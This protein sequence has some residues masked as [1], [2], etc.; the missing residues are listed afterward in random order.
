M[1]SIAEKVLEQYAKNKA[2]SGSGGKFSS[3][4]ERMKKYF[5]TILPKGKTEGEKRIRILPTKD[6]S[7]PFVEVRFH[8]ISVDGKWLKLY[9]PAQEGKRSPLNEVYAALKETGDPDDDVLAR[10]YRSRTF[11]IV[12]LIDRDN[13]EDGVKF[14]RFKHNHKSD[15]IL[16]K[17]IPI[18][19]KRGNITDVTDEEGRDISLTLTLTKANNGKDYTIVSSVIPEDKEVLHTD[20]EKIKEWVDDE[21][22]WKDVYSV[23]S[24]EYL[25]MVANGETPRWD[26]VQKKFVSASGDVSEATI[27]EESQSDKEEKSEPEVKVKPEVKDPQ[28][29][30]K[31]D[32]DLPF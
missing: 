11:Y 15:G 16:D 5:T 1:S 27:G 31:V 6:G 26:N 13:E 3:Q 9:D 12:K 2:A 21:L 4:E 7:S 19:K 8:E 20:E 23:R 24:E 17:I 28:K 29:D 10:S 22:T 14:W 25:D 18:F 32:D 30:D